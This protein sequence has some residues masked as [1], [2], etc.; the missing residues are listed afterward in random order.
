MRRNKKLKIKKIIT[1]IT[2]LL[3]ILFGVLLIKEKLNSEPYPNDETNNQPGQTNPPDNNEQNEPEEKEETPAETEKEPEEESGEEP[4]EETPEDGIIIENPEKIDVLVNKKRNLPDSYVPED[5]VTLSEVPTVLENPEVNQMRNAAYEALK[6]LFKA[7]QDEEGYELYARS[8]YRSYNTQTSLYSSYV[9]SYGKEA[10]DKYS[11]KP[12]QSEHQTGL[13]I[14][15]TCE[16]LNFRLDDT[17]GE[18]EEGK[19]VAENAHRFGYIIRYPKDKEDITGYM[20]EPWHIRY[21][22]TELAGKV[23]ESGLTLEEYLE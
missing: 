5:L 11:A 12:G 18:T 6:E 19:W 16:A 21:L 7:A 2:A 17:F 1:C 22:G 20:Y 23:F 3:L 8:G 10:A 13:S 4:I 15:I 9:E 14:D